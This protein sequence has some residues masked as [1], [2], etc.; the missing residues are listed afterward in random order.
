MNYAQ[1]IYAPLRE[2]GLSVQ[3]ARI[4][5]AEIGWENSFNPDFLFGSHTDPKNGATNVGLISWQRIRVKK[6]IMRL[7]AKDLYKNGKKTRSKAS[8]DRMVK[9]MLSEISSNPAYSKTKSE[10]LNNPKL[11][12]IKDTKY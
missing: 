10:F 5:T 1:Q 11:H 9:Y 4:M 2:H 8:L 3:Q 6:L 7:T 12:T